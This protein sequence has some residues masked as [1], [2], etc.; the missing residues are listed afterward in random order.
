MIS[1][2]STERLLWAMLTVAVYLLMCSVIITRQWRQ[3]RSVAQAAAALMPAA[4]GA[5]TWLVTYASQTGN[6]EQLAW[7]TGR[8][9]HTAGVAAR[10]MSLAQLRTEELARTERALLIVSTYGEGDPPDTAALFARKVM[11]TTPSLA[12]LHYGLLALGDNTYK[13][14]CGFGRALDSWLQNRGAQPL[15]E[16]IEVNND[17][18]QALAKWRHQLSH[19]AGTDDVPDWQAPNFEQWRLHA[20]RQLNIGSAGNPIYHLE[21]KPVHEVLPMWQSGDLVQIL[22]PADP[23]RA[24]E[25]SIA[26]IPTDGSIHLLVRQELHEDGTLGIASGWLTAQSEPGTHLELRVRP[27]HNFQLGDNAQRDLILIGNGTG[28]AGLRAHLK[29]R[30]GSSRRN[31]LIF[32]E[33]NAAFDAYYQDEIAAWQHSGVLTRMDWVFSR[34]QSQRRY[35]QDRLRECADELRT[36]LKDGAA[37]YVC[38]SLEGMA[39][40]VEKALADIVG[41]DGVDQLI[42]AGRYRRDVY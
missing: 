38:G 8:A 40:G 42:E 32:G 12:S 36:W 39:S 23:Q 4:A 34:D 6:A 7:Q 26:S 30:T 3:R 5:H 35:V 29:A 14:F 15:F 16:R 11:A 10:V 9:L 27:H 25:Y 20:R 22:A 2:I 31:W 28:L 19:L 41:K 33:R 24:R 1:G 37:I 17:D 18:A 13:H 21:L